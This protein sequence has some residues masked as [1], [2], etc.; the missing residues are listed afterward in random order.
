MGSNEPELIRRIA[1]RAALGD[2][3]LRSP[4][5][6]SG[7]GTCR[8]SSPPAHP[9]ASDPPVSQ[10]KNEHRGHVGI[11][12]TRETALTWTCWTP[13]NTAEH[14]CTG[15]CPFTHQRSAVRYRPRPPMF[16]QVSVIRRRPSFNVEAPS[17]QKR[18]TICEMEFDTP[19]TEF[20]QACV[21]QS[22]RR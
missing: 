12:R 16:V 2:I 8:P 10:D 4:T 11:N 15:S 20:S 3:A 7:C 5:C 6:A 17:S 14:L 9:F 18:P 1:C 21:A 22:F 19:L 13:Q